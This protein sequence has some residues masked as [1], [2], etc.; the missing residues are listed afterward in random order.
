MTCRERLLR[1]FKRQETDR[2]PIRLWGVDPLNP[3]DDWKVLYQLIE[4]YE[5]EIIRDWTPGSDEWPPSSVK[6]RIE[7]GP[8]RN[9]QQE[10]KIIWETPQGPLTEIFC[11]FLDG[12]PGRCVKYLIE[13][14][15]DA[16]KYLS[17][18]SRTQLPKLDSYW[19]L[20]R[21]TGERALLMVGI[22]EA[23]YSIQ[24]L[25]GSETFGYWLY[26]YRQL[27]HLMISRSFQFLERL[28]K[29]YLSN[30]LG[31]AYG[32]VGPELCIPP[33]ASVRDFQEFVVAY[34]RRIAELIHQAGKVV[35]VHCHGDMSEVL[36]G[37]MDLGVDCLNP[38]EPPPVSKITLSQAKARCAGRMTLE[39]NVEDG[40]FDCLKPEEMKKLVEDTV[41]QGKPGGNFILCPTSSP[42]TWS[43]LPEHVETNY[44]IFVETA[45][46][47]RNY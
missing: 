41:R 8:V 31:D 1:V 13:T 33:L 12:S 36:E 4:K 9:G 37:F 6:R 39:G 22:D 19:E 18:P 10:V 28:V 7:K 35:W 16:E 23:M 34:D 29:H 32:W 27:L 14:P 38:I 21:K 46:S 40:A 42:T 5:L 43:R 20:K 44:R 11:S 3:R 24:R 26:D 47:M 15:E 25:M 2:M 17:L 45:V 30:N